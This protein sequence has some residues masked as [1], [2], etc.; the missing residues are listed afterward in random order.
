MGRFCPRV[1]GKRQ[2]ERR[3]HHQH[4]HALT[5]AT[6]RQH[7]LAYRSQPQGRHRHTRH[8]LITASS[9]NSSTKLDPLEQTV[10]LPS[11]EIEF[12][13]NSN[14]ITFRIINASTMDETRR[15]RPSSRPRTCEWPALVADP[16]ALRP[17]R[18]R[19][20]GLERPQPGATERQ[21]A[22]F[23]A[24]VFEDRQRSARLLAGSH[25]RAEEKRWS[26]CARCFG[27]GGRGELGMNL[28]CET[29]QP[30]GCI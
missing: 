21:S 17:R 14:I 20:R 30:F 23:E 6:T 9:R 28:R 22:K 2:Q 18:I 8:S 13:P 11:P 12:E 5:P 24:M 1:R 16:R 7:R 25:W 10:F 19:Q 3:Q 29:E 26:S 4:S 27:C 15:R